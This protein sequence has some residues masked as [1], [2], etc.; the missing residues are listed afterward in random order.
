[1]ERQLIYYI[2]THTKNIFCVNIA[3][4]YLFNYPYN[5]FHVSWRQ[6]ETYT[7]PACFRNQVS[8][9]IPK[10]PVTITALYFVAS[11]KQHAPLFHNE[12]CVLLWVIQTFSLLNRLLCKSGELK[13]QETCFLWSFNYTNTTCLLVTMLNLKRKTSINKK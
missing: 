1:M 10:E 3:V 11:L 4:I 6:D 8:S 5:C 2:Q 7:L 12:V 13:F 9:C